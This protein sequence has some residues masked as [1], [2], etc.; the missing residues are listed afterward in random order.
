MIADNATAPKLCKTC[1]HAMRAIQLVC[2]KATN[3]V[4]G[5]AAPCE[6]VRADEAMCGPQASWWSQRMNIAAL[7]DGYNPPIAETP[8]ATIRTQDD[9][10]ILRKITRPEDYKRDE[11]K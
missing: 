2:D 9:P 5:D 8:M 6:T 11:W 1:K 4:T 7:V 10:T 3:V